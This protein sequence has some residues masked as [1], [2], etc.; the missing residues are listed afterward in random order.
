[1]NF[2]E[3]KSNE[4]NKTPLKE[5]DEKEKIYRIVYSTYGYLKILEEDLKNNELSIYKFAQYKKDNFNNY[6]IG[7]I[8]KDN[9]K[10]N[11]NLRIK[12]FSGKRDIVLLENIDVNV[13]LNTLIEKIFINNNTNNDKENLQKLTKNS[14]FRFFSCKTC[15]RELNT[16]YTIFESGLQ[17]NELLIF[18]NEVPLTF[19]SIIKGK[20]IQLSQM[21]KTALKINTDEKQYILGCNGYISGKHYFEITLFTEPMIR[22]I[23]VGFSNVDDPNNLSVVMQKLYGFILSDEKKTVVHFGTNHREDMNDYGEVCTINDKIGVLF[24]CRSDGVYISFYR[25]K[26]N[27]G[28]AFEKLPNNLIYFPTVEMGLCGSKVQITNEVDFPYSN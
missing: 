20:S 18:F 12:F 16:G 10:Q 9:I 2:G 28:I 17:D 5:S 26:K 13:K 11:I 21:N 15:L 6:L 1:M 27:L 24:D 25:N 22:S 14:Q 19:S 8:F 3:K 23:V 4:E 7:T